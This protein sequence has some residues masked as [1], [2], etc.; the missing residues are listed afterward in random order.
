MKFNVIPVVTAFVLASTYS[1]S[2]SSQYGELSDDDYIVAS[3]IRN[4]GIRNSEVSDI[5]FHLSDVIGPRL[6][7]SKQLKLANEWTAEKMQ[8]FGLQKIDIDPYEFGRGWDFS[9][10]SVHMISPNKSPVLALPIAWSAGTQGVK[11]GEA[12]IVDIKDKQ[13]FEKYRGK[14]KGKILFLNEPRQIVSAP[15]KEVSKSTTYRFTEQQLADISDYDIDREKEKA[16]AENR[17]LERIWKEKGEVSEGGRKEYLLFKESQD[18]F[19]AEGAIATV[20][21]SS[22]DMGLISAKGVLLR[23]GDLVP[24]TGLTMASEH[25]NRIIRL[26]ERDIPV[27]LEIDVRAEVL[28]SGPAHNTF[29]EITGTDKS[30]EMVMVGAHLDSWH[31]GTGAS[32]NGAGVAIT[33]EAMRILK[34]LGIKP[35]R[36]IRIALWGGEEQ[37]GIV[38]NNFYLGSGAYMDKTVGTRHPAEEGE[39]KYPQHLRK[40][41][42][43]LLLKKGQ[44]K[45]SA[46]YNIDNG[47]GRIRGVWGQN[48]YAAT[49]IFKEWLVPFADLGANT[50]TLRGAYGSDHVAYDLFGI[51]GFQFIQDPLE[52]ETHL[53][54]TNMDVFDHASEIDMKQAATILAFFLYK[55]AMM[56]EVI[57]RKQLRDSRYI[58]K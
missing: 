11:Q 57:P 51:P 46:Y 4:E 3:K 10:T 28:P 58:K 38:H 47:G 1:F 33:M 24:I 44:K 26:L 21:I 48:N 53:H 13:D 49:A 30:K 39:E 20:R 32:D 19:R 52:Y 15:F 12:M 43:G 5:L 56:D 31:V 7:G 14:L 8:S 2:A 29:G 41:P 9:Y 37:R 6:T 27:R 45:I 18:F 22:Y 17:T 42:A 36:T 16:I 34:A 55:T 54:H 40:R 50:V 35:K 23:K 25:Y